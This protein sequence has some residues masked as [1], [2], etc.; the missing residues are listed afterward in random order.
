M[1][2]DQQQTP[3]PTQPPQQVSAPITQ[4]LPQ[5]ESSANPGKGLAI[6]GIV[7][8]FL[9]L[10]LIGLIL[11]II[12]VIKARAGSSAKIMAIVGIVLNIVIGTV[13]A[14]IGGVILLAAYN[15]IQNRATA[16]AFVTA[17]Q[18]N[19]VNRATSLLK[20][21]TDQRAK[22][23]ITGFAGKI[24]TSHTILDTVYDN[25]NK[26]YA[27]VFQLSGGQVKYTKITLAL[28]KGGPKVETFVFSNTKLSSTPNV[29]SQNGIVV[30]V[31]TPSQ[32]A[33]PSTQTSKQCLTTQDA[34]SLSRGGIYVPTTTRTDGLLASYTTYFQPTA[35]V[36]SYPS[37]TKLVYDDLASFILQHKASSLK[38]E[39]EV[40]TPANVS[41]DAG[42]AITK[43]RVLAIY[44]ALVGRGVDASLL[45][46]SGAKEK[47]DTAIISLHS[48]C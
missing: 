32:Q 10:Q 23:F 45:S 31:S 13:S 39:V 47:G 30:G 43:E 46:I 36:E 5:A 28:G 26:K 27:A 4:T 11:S 20:D 41:S 6:A 22:E 7:L 38:V 3:P 42:E 40:T 17:V 16:D 9:P 48:G 2:Q 35:S 29:E 24:G 44:Q 8:A 37:S 18:E 34:A 33:A 1:N 19:D 25:E 12:A 15:G 21:P 14:L